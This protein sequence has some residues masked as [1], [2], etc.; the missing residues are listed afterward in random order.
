MSKALKKKLLLRLKHALE[1]RND[2]LTFA[3]FMMP[4]P[5]TPDD[6]SKSQYSVKKHHQ[7]I[8]AA[9]E[10]VEKGAIKRLI[11][12]LPPRAGKSLLVSK[13]FP[14]WYLGRHPSHHIITATYNENFAWDFG[15][16]VRDQLRNP[17]YNQVFPGVALKSGAAAADRVEV[18]DGGVLYFTGRGGSLTGRGGH[19]LLVDDPIKDRKEADSQTVRDTCWNWFNQVFSTRMMTDSAAVVIIMTRW[20][21]DDLVGRLIDPSNSYYNPDE[22]KQWKVINIPALAGDNDPLGRK[23]GESL[24]PERFSKTFLEGMRRKD[25]RGFQAL[26]QGDPTPPD[27]AFF[28][29]R[30]IIAYTKPH[31]MP[32]RDEM[33]FYAASDHAVS[34]EQGRDKTCFGVVGVDRQDRIW[35]M[36]D[37]FWQQAPTNLVVEAMIDTMAKYN[38]LFW[39]AERGHIS[40]SIGPFLRKRMMERNVYCAIDEI[41]PTHD[42]QTRAQSIHGRIA[43]G[44]VR[45]PSFAHW[46]PDA[47]NELLKFPNGAHDD[48]VDF[49]SLVGMGLA[50]TVARRAPEPVKKDPEPGTVGWVLWQSR[51]EREARKREAE[52]GGW[53]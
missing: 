53:L 8:C 1:S 19:L 20:H 11:I 28:D 49:L 45:F 47:K 32:N 13:L 42:K 36:P 50:K 22:A 46:W 33:M 7:V 44:R 41:T 25:P 34:M 17:L 52:K 16:G 38:P 5:N 35:V 40:K 12:S 18:T 39:W 30:S 23:P 51:L 27:G 9:L 2:M 48:F 3:R 26:Y 10:E 4:D 31:D 14:V 37:I 6:T 15:R 29:M 43:M 21:E 24:W